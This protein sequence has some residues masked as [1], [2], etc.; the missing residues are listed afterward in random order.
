MNMNWG[1]LLMGIDF[2]EILFL[3]RD[4][5]DVKKMKLYIFKKWFLKVFIMLKKENNIKKILKLLF[6]E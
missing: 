6:F 3:F 2:L 4:L 5:W 1:V